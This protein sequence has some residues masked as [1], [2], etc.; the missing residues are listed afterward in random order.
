MISDKLKFLFS[1]PCSFYC[2]EP[3][4]ERCL[5]IAHH[6]SV[7]CVSALDCARIFFLTFDKYQTYTY[8]ILSSKS[9]TDSVI[10]NRPHVIPSTMRALSGMQPISM[11]DIVTH[12]W[13]T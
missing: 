8:F 9:V 10:E 13:Y 3:F 12:V 5:Q 7:F 6:W 4:R 1:V 2:A 11:G